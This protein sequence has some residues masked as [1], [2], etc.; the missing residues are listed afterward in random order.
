M[1]SCEPLANQMTYL[2]EIELEGTVWK[3]Q[4]FSDT[5]IFHEINFSDF[6][7]PKTAI[8]RHLEALNFYS[9]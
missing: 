8:L 5:Q 2:V 4:K 7:G 1:K 6:R 9:L 3:F